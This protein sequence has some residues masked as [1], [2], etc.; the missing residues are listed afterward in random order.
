MRIVTL[1]L[2]LVIAACAPADHDLTPEAGP[3]AGSVALN[4][5]ALLATNGCGETQ[6]QIQQRTR[7]Y[8][9]TQLT[10]SWSWSGAL[11]STWYGTASGGRTA[12]VN[13]IGVD[14]LDSVQ[15]YVMPSQSTNWQALCKCTG[16]YKSC[17]RL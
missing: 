14:K 7:N 5:E 8:V 13:R 2:T 6:T 12:T 16:S 1:L 3:Q 17:Q 4:T 9:T 11:G 15:R 10:G